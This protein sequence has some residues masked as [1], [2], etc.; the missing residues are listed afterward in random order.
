M[1]DAQRNETRD[2]NEMEIGGLHP[3]GEPITFLCNRV[4][5][6]RLRSPGPL[7]TVRESF[8]SHSSSLSNASK[9]TRLR[10]GE[11]LAMDRAV[12][13]WMKQNPILGAGGTT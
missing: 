1:L 8:P 12:A 5:G 10:N 7:R 2:R 4:A 9:E 11:T 3:K 6:A 13:L